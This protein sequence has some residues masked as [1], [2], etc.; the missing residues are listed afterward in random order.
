MKH[1]SNS[2]FSK[3]KLTLDLFSG[4]DPPAGGPASPARRASLA[5]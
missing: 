1:V 4:S 5:G 3:E 2:I